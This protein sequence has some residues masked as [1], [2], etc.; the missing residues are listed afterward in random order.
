M[1]DKTILGYELTNTDTYE[2]IYEPKR[3]Y[4]TTH[5]FITCFEC[6]SA[7]SFSGGPR[8]NS[9]CLKCFD[10]HKLESFINGR[11]SN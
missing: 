8:H 3:R 6:G 10:I 7:I 1:N 4:I 9:L 2:P 11:K 5:A